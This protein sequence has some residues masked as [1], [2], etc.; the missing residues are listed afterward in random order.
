MANIKTS[1][2]LINLHLIDKDAV[3]TFFTVSL[4]FHFSV[5]QGQPEGRVY[6]IVQC[7][8]PGSS[9]CSQGD[10]TLLTCGS[11]AAAAAA[12]LVFT[13]FACSD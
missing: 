4:H 2:S 9:G 7:V 6:S 13:K 8:A 1:S 3:I 11:A 12:T 10:L 5:G